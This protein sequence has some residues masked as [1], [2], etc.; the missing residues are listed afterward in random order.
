MGAENGSIKMG[1][2]PVSRPQFP[3]PRLLFLKERGQFL[4]ATEYNKKGPVPFFSEELIL[5]V[6]L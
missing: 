6:M 1:P 5:R 2:G 4:L 3:I